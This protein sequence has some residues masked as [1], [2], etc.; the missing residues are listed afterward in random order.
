M[1]EHLLPTH[2]SQNPLGHLHIY[3][4]RGEVSPSLDGTVNRG[5]ERRLCDS[6]SVTQVGRGKAGITPMPGWFQSLRS[7]PS[8]LTSQQCLRSV[9]IW[10]GGPR[11]AVNFPLLVA[12]QEKTRNSSVASICLKW[13]PGES[14][15]RCSLLLSLMHSALLVGQ[16]FLC[17]L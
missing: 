11:Q 1:G 13:G 15:P 12:P 9:Q 8:S 6:P 14:H 17:L 2:T 10:N 3:L 5:P 4:W 16:H 7:Y